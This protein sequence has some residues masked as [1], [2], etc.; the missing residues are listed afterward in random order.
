MTAPTPDVTV[1]EAMAQMADMFTSLREVANGLKSQLI[2]DFWS[3]P[4]AEQ[5]AA[6]AFSAALQI[7]VNGGKK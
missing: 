2:R 7:V 1:T 3:E 6:N 5:M 4:A